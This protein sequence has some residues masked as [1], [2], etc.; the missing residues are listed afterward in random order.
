MTELNDKLINYIDLKTVTEAL[1]NKKADKATTLAGYGIKDAYTSTE[2]NG[3][4]ENK[5]NKATTLAGYGITDAFTKSDVT[6]KLGGK[7]DKSTTLAG[8]GITNA[9]TKGEVDGMVSSVYEPKGSKAFASLPAP[10]ASM[11]GDVYNVTDA[12]TTDAKFVEG[13]GKKFPAGTNVVIVKEG[14]AYKYDVLAGTIDLS[15]YAK[16]SDLDPYAK[17]SAMQSGLAGKVDKVDG[18]RLIT[19][20]EVDKLNALA[21]GS[22]KV[23]KST[24]NG[25]I[26]ING[27]ETKVYTLPSSVRQEEVAT[28]Q[29]VQA[30]LTGL[31]L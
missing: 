20:A 11:I 19:Q 24:T 12:F 28:L 22:T 6:S 1:N 14:N 23:E 29:E 13:S 9:Y 18:S 8:Y 5:A 7:A 4:L 31:G 27:A 2:T 17:T 25:N 16:K 21:S 30:M 3:L 15:S 26:K 10:T